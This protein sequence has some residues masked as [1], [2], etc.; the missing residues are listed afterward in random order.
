[1]STS[2]PAGSGQPSGRQPM[3]RRKALAIAAV[4]AILIV[5]LAVVN[6]VR[7][8]RAAE[9]RERRVDNVVAALT[10]SE[11][12]YEVEGDAAYADVTMETPT[13]QSQQ[14]PDLPMALESG[15]GPLTFEFTPGSFVY[16]SAQNPDE[17]GDITCRITVDGVVV[18]EN[19]SSGGF[20]IATCKG[21]A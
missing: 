18:S 10:P 9:E 3:D 8:S 16:L 21:R 14:S 13:G 7:E 17:S 12:V 19:T 6:N 4:I 2:E 11:V 15:G 20:A 5:V 1:M